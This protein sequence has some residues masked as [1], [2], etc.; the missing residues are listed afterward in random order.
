[1]WLALKLCVLSLWLHASKDY[2]FETTDVSEAWL[3]TDRVVS[4]L[5]SR[6]TASPWEA[7]TEA[8]EL[9]PHT[10]RSLINCRTQSRQI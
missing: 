2:D 10:V 3:I 8:P 4:C 1:M 7:E 5:V 6:I 9:H